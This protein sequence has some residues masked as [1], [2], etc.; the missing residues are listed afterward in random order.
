M[1]GRIFLLGT[2][3]SLTPMD[4]QIYEAE[5]LLQQLLAEHPD[6]LAGDQ[7]DPG[8]P[9]QWLLISREVG[10]PGSPGSQNRWSL[11]HLFVD[12]DGVPTLVEVKRS[13]NSQ[14]RREI[15]GQLLDY[16]A[17]GT[18]YW[19]IDQMI[20]AFE[21]RCERDMADPS[22]VLEAFLSSEED[23]AVR[24]DAA[25][26]WQ[27]VKVNLQAGRIRMMFVADEIPAELRR[28]IEFLNGQMDPAQVLGLEVRQYVG[29]NGLRTL[30]P[31]VVGFTEHARQQKEIRAR[32]TSSWEQWE[33]LLSPSNYE[34]AR[35]M[36]D[37]IESLI[38]ELG[39]PWR[40]EFR[41]GW[42]AFKASS[43]RSV[44]G[45]D[46]YNHRP[47]Q[48]WVK[49]PAPITE[50]Q[51]LDPFPE[52]TSYWD[53]PNKQWEWEVPTPGAVPDVAEVVAIARQFH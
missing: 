41:S 53:A 14:I 8:S 31:N 10:V 15:V 44:I 42:I 6:L 47:I 23:A 17:N 46:L 50:L 12:Q 37:R 4:E 51:I 49:L 3:A 5:A 32:G 25:E 13:T 9:R 24:T 39:L 26:F 28:I 19:S 36:S 21:R 33:K 18:A 29:S 40:M 30:V 22:L 52:L 38:A 35:G 16:A 34:I 48:L 45:M 27:K 2:D 1:T 43:K 11:D 7:I 20:A